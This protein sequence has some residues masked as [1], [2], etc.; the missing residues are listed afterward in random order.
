MHERP[1]RIGRGRSARGSLA[2]VSRT[3]DKRAPTDHP[4]ADLLAR[5]WS[6]R[7]F[8]DRDVSEAD[9]LT[10]FEAARWAPSS[11]NRQP[12]RFLVATRR[13]PQEHEQLASVLNDRNR[14]WAPSAPVLALGVAHVSDG[15]R[16]L[17]YGSY[18]LG[19]A[20]G[21]LLVQATDLGLYVHQMA[22]YDRRRARE[23]F[24]IPDDFE[25]MAVMAI[26]HPGDVDALPEDLRARELA[27]R[28]RRA[29]AEFVFTGRFGTVRT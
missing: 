15:G 20:V 26:G 22:G 17:P 8:A 13:E 2:S 10:L 4:I 16:P 25:P 14:R 24:G 3:L 28:G 12:W 19:Q 23:L 18:D 7:A 27:P 5:R 11:S 29:V 9:L 1:I 6:P 21:M